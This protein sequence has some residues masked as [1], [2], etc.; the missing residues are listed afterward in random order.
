MLDKLKFM[1]WQ[2]ESAY[3]FGATG[4]LIVAVA[5]HVMI[6]AF[7]LLHYSALATAGILLL[8]EILGHLGGNPQFLAKVFVRRT[9]VISF[10]IMANVL[11]A[12]LLLIFYHP[13]RDPMFVITSAVLF[14]LE[15]ALVGAFIRVL[16]VAYLGQILRGISTKVSE[17]VLLVMVAVYLFLFPTSNAHHVYAV[18][19][20]IG[21]ATGFLLHFLK[22][23]FE[24]RTAREARLRGNILAR[25]AGT[26]LSRPESDAVDYYA[27]QQWGRLRRL[28]QKHKS[29][30]TMTTALAIVEASGERSRSKYA[31]AL[32]LVY[33]E[34]KR[35]GANQDLFTYLHLLRALCHG[36]LNHPD[37]MFAALET[38]LV[39]S[40]NCVLAK[41]TWALRIAERASSSKEE[42]SQADSRINEAMLLSERDLP[43]IWALT[44]GYT[45]PVT[46]TFLLDAYAYVSMQNG[47]RR[48]SKVLFEHCIS[49]DPKFGLP[50]VHLGE[51]YLALARDNAVLTRDD[52]RRKQTTVMGQNKR[53]A[54]LCLYIAKELEGC[55]N[56]LVSRRA[57]DFLS[58][59]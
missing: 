8:P 25:L 36:D 51:W 57:S 47:Q 6:D 16:F 32:N 39:V 24:Q 9:E 27:R 52:V 43:N 56:N 48:L 21:V 5:R 55:R 35:P 19:Y 54:R 14:V 2:K 31:D 44:V 41:A 34:F 18:P 13:L 1:I 42:L 33:D 26:E 28:L 59:I 50:Y 38:S 49:V 11:T 7:R 40:P 15:G 53:V 3:T 37:D 30:G 45:V 46:P 29:L 17:A 58:K 10:L 23:G 22:R 4:L 20:L 12:A